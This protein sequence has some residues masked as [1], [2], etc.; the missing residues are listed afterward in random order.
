MNAANG[1]GVIDTDQ[2]TIMDYLFI[3]PHRKDRLARLTLGL[4][5]N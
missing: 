5:G 2:P 3:Q 4:F 1:I